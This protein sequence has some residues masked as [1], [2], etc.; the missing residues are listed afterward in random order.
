ML[1]LGGKAISFLGSTILRNGAV[2]P[3]RLNASEFSGSARNVPWARSVVDPR[4]PASLSS[5]YIMND[6][7]HVT[8]RSKLRVM[9]RFG[10]NMI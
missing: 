1:L 10:L 3:K 2:Q 5:L 8:Q 6:A 7:R 4:A 9:R